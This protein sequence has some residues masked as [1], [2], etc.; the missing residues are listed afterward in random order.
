MRLAGRSLRVVMHERATCW[1]PPS[2][3][4][5]DFFPSCLTTH[6]CANAPPL[7]QLQDLHVIVFFSIIHLCHPLGLVI[8]HFIELHTWIRWWMNT[9]VLKSISKLEFAISIE[10]QL[11]LFGWFKVGKLAWKI[12]TFFP[13]LIVK[14]FRTTIIGFYWHLK[15]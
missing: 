11:P 10:G 9:F 14:C 5:C 15:D 2:C 12:N 1:H 7:E 8:I 13:L 4:A 3:A 6:C